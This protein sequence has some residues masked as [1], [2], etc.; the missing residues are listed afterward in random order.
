M[1]LLTNNGLAYVSLLSTCMYVLMMNS[2]YF[3]V[4]PSHFRCKI[5]TDLK[6]GVYFLWHLL[7]PNCF[8][9]RHFIIS[10]TRTTKS[11]LKYIISGIE[12][13]YSITGVKSGVRVYTLFILLLF[14]YYFINLYRYEY[15]I[16]YR[17]I[18]IVI[19]VHINCI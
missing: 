6:I 10:M 7:N 4:V 11:V 16:I 5:C 12:V 8:F 1:T 9:H 2:M 14:Y 13:S 19:L 18:C 3:C 17:Y 15:Y